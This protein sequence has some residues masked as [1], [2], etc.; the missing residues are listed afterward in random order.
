MS[1]R[2]PHSECHGAQCLMGGS[3]TPCGTN[4]VHACGVC[5]CMAHELLASIAAALYCTLEALMVSFVLV[6]SRMGV[7]GCSTQSVPTS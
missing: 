4:A 3:S 7:A 5:I 6:T 1:A 2:C